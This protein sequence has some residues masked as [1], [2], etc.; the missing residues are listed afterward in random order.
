M[1]CRHFWKVTENTLDGKL[2]R[3]ADKC[4]SGSCCHREVQDESLL[5]LI[6]YQHCTRNQIKK[7]EIV[8]KQMKV[9]IQ[10]KS[11]SADE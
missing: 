5:D 6:P 2:L 11:P 1:K 4:R 8:Q 3:H 7:N 9:P 10:R